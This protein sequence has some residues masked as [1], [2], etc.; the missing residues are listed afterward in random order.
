[1]QLVYYTGLADALQHLFH[2]PEFTAKVAR[3]RQS[4]VGSP[5]Q[6]RGWQELD[7]RLDGALNAPAPEASCIP[8]HVIAISAGI[9]WGQMHTRSSRSTGLLLMRYVQIIC[10]FDICWPVEISRDRLGCTACSTYH[11]CPFLSSYLGFSLSPDRCTDLDPI[12]KAKRRFH[13]LLAVIPPVIKSDGK[14]HEP[15]DLDGCI[16]PFLWDLQRY[17]PKPPVTLASEQFKAPSLPRDQ[18]GQGLIITPRVLQ[19]DTQQVVKG[20]AFQIACGADRECSRR[21]SS[22]ETAEVYRVHRVPGLFLVWHEWC[23]VSW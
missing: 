15:T 20:C 2:S 1:M 14:A 11:A 6:S 7:T 17:G 23:S 16:L 9:D 10:L 18:M 21:H 13:K 12:T 22:P 19:P 4:P 5:F 8:H 3:A